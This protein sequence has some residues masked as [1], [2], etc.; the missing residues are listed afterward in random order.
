MPFAHIC[1]EWY[2]SQPIPQTAAII[3]ID[4]IAS[5]LYIYVNLNRLKLLTALVFV[6]GAA[7]GRDD[8]RIGRIALDFTPE[9]G[10][11]HIHRPRP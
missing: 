8:F 4:N 6:T 1:M 10:D 5:H 9:L 3:I 11:V 7:D 2:P